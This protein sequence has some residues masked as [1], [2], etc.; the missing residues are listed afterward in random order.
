[1]LEIILEFLHYLR[2]VFYF[3]QYRTN[4]NVVVV[5]LWESS[6]SSKFFTV[7]LMLAQVE[8]VLVIAESSAVLRERLELRFCEVERNISFELSITRM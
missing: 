3:L 5:R 2:L 8:E 7:P 1:M 4:C 6:E